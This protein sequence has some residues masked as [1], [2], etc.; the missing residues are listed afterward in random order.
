MKNGNLTKY[1]GMRLN[2]RYLLFSCRTYIWSTIVVRVPPVQYTS[3]AARRH[4]TYIQ[5]YNIILEKS[6]IKRREQLP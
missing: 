3:A 6:F 2:K 1:N 4:V 5:L